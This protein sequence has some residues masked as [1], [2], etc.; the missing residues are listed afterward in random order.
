MSNYSQFF[1]NTSSRVVQL[2][3]ID[4]F[5][6]NFSQRY[7]IVRNAINGVT[8]TL[9]DT[10]VGVFVYYPVKITPT[11]S[12]NDLDQTLQLVF[13]DLGQILPLE[14]DRLLFQFGAPPLFI[15][16]CFGVWT[17]SSGV[18]VASPFQ[19]G[20][21]CTVF[22]P[23]GAAFLSMGCNNGFFANSGTWAVVIKDGTNTNTVTVHGWA[24]PWSV[25][26]NP[27]YS[28]GTVGSIASDTFAVTPGALLQLS[29]SGNGGNFAN[30]GGG[31][32]SRPE[33]STAG[34]FPGSYVKIA[35]PSSISKPVV[36]YRTYRSDDLTQ[37]LVG[38]IKFEMD[39][40]AFQKQGATIQCSARKLN[41]TATGELYTM[42][43]FPMLKGFL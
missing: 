17:D 32:P 6:P 16:S 24:R 35:L 21:G 9:E 33:I 27:T 5:H 28:F 10:T 39:S 12:S 11:G 15:D 31:D 40:V 18:I 23:P 26:L 14:V 29:C 25:T 8:V 42:D 19:I 3:L 20:T 38:P 41:L 22:V 2:E 36:L 37:P 4:I 43:R 13:G 34:I 7:R 1:L 30:S